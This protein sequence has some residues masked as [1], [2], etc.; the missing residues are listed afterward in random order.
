MFV[1]QNVSTAENIFEFITTQYN[2]SPAGRKALAAA[3][4]RILQL[5]PDDP[6]QGSPFNTGNE[7]FGLSSQFKRHSAICTFL[8]VSD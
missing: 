8:R 5:Y 7:T 6:V 2:P 4:R 3:T 1:P